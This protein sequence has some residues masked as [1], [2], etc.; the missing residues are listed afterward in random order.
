MPQV[1][2]ISAWGQAF[3]RMPNRSIPTFSN[4]YLGYPIIPF[5]WLHSP[6]SDEL[7]FISEYLYD[8]RLAIHKTVKLYRN[9]T[10]YNPQFTLLIFILIFYN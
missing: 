7:A 9:A 1:S 6:C 10:S 5:D 8:Q 2:F 3:I 4:I